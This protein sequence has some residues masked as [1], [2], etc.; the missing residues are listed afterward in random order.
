M[1]GFLEVQNLIKTYYVGDIAVHAL[2]GLNLNVD[3]GEFVLILGPSGSGKSTLLN[4]LA[5][6]DSVTEGTILYSLNGNGSWK[7]V[8]DITKMNERELSKFRRTF[9]GYIFQFYNL[10]PTM[11]ALENVELS[12]RFGNQPNP[13]EIALEMLQAVSL[14]GKEYKRPRQLSGGEQ[15][16]VAIARALAKFPTIILA[17]EPTGNV[18]SVTSQAIYNLMKSLNETHE[19]TFIIVT[20][21]ES[22]AHMAQRHLHLLDGVIIREDFN[23]Q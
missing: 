18:D 9:V 6:I 2:H 23:G 5:G 21:D 4:L 15:Q 1:P 22:M 20:H 3:K 19:I 14:K 10:I 16:R 13:R 7:G 12:A 11:S 8:R 17:D